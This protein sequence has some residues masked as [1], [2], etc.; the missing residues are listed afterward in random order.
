MNSWMK[1][2][3]YMTNFLTMADDE[4]GQSLAEYGLIL[5]LIAVVCILAVT[6]LGNGIKGQL[7]TLSSE[8]GT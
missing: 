1:Y 5:A 3:F 8:F 6:A 2:Y 4:E 7:N